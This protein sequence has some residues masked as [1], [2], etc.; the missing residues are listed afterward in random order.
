MLNENDKS[1]KFYFIRH[2]E[3]WY[4]SI[5]DK[6]VKFNPDYADSHL[7]TKG[8]EQAKSIQEH[9]NK[10]DIEVIYVSP[11]YR[12][13]ETMKYAFDNHPNLKN[14]IAFVHPKI[15]ELSGMMHE[16]ILD[17]KQTKK[18]FNMNSKLKVNWSIFDE[19]TK[20]NKYGENLFFF[21]NWNLIEDKAKTEIANKLNNLYEKEDIKTYKKEISKIVEDRYKSGLKFESYKHAFERFK[22]FK[23]YLC[24]KHKDNMQ[25][26]DKKIIIISHRLYI[27][28]G[29]SHC[30][31]DSDNV[32]KTSSDC[33]MLKNC[34]IA[35]F[36]L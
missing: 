12:C 24:E 22:D 1:Y 21:D 8:I 6:S 16:F 15:A 28:I 2:G 18:D 19:Y 31:Y 13:L 4:N 9:L 35:P 14:I 5:S 7:S 32:K 30:N 10:L 34:E 33:L 26:K 23:N 3:T 25:N 20:N 36:L 11:Y 27:S 17:I 29:T